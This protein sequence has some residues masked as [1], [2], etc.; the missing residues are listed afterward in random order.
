MRA[1]DAAE[2]AS[3]SNPDLL[4]P[5]KRE[6]LGLLGE[7]VQQELRWH[8]ALMI[9]RLQLT[10][11]ER[12]RAAE[13]LEVY[14]EDRSSI[15]K[16]FAMQGLADLARQDPGLQVEVREQ[17][18]TLTRTGTPAMKARGRKLLTELER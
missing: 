12:R 9:P 7:A 11:V 14:L 15:V 2:K 3:R 6:L 4:Q 16:T 5:H 17:I 18:R 1:A 13:C 10:A 8:L